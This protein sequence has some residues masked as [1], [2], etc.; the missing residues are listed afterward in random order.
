MPSESVLLPETQAVKIPRSAKLHRLLLAAA[1]VVF[2]LALVEFPAAINLVDYHTIIGARPADSFAG[3][4]VNDPELLHVHRPHLRLIGSARG[5]QYAHQYQ[6]PPSDMTLY[7]WDAKYDRN[8]F[9]NE[10][11]LRRADVAVIGDSFVEGLTVPDPELT[12]SHL[13]AWRREVVANLGQ[14][15]YGPQQELVV[16]KRYGLP[17][18]PRTVVWMFFEGNDLKDVVD[19]RRARQMHLDFW[20]TFY[21]RSFTR[22]SVQEIKKLLFAPAK[23][24]GVEPSALFQT[25]GGGEITIYFGSPSA[26]LSEQDISALYETISTL[27]AAYKLC[28]AQNARLIFVFVPTKFRVFRDYCQLPQRSECRN[29]VVNDLPKR[30]RNAMASISPDLG[31]VDL[32]ANFAAAVRGGQMPYYSD[33][34]HLS[35]EGHKIAAEAINEVLSRAGSSSTGLSFVQAAH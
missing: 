31:F 30:L 15:G 3:G 12:T 9:R 26:A 28:A 16:L 21:L 10:D 2:A 35:P 4:N 29:W 25:S 8:G 1:S 18:L 24:L 23:P 19:Y 6:I 27:S 33:D 34:P 11:D 5:G 13:A 22:N 32:T 14:G 17:L 7:K 20:H